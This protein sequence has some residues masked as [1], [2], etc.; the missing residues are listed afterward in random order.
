MRRHKIN[1]TSKQQISPYQKEIANEKS[2]AMRKQ[3]ISSQTLYRSNNNNNKKNHTHKKRIVLSGMDSWVKEVS[4]QG[5]IS[6]VARR[7]YQPLFCWWMG[8]SSFQQTECNWEWTNRNT[9]N[10]DWL[11]FFFFLSFEIKLN[12]IHTWT[13]GCW[14]SCLG[15]ESEY[16][17]YLNRSRCSLARC[18]QD[19]PAV[20]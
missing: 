8:W 7:Q 9:P 6:L 17:T 5:R 18:C 10:D 20:C 4:L 14:I 1:V 13:G 2:K 11:I 19:L 16:N 3:E 12:T 15:F